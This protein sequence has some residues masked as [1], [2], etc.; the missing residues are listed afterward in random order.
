MQ[1]RGGK[2]TYYDEAVLLH[3]LQITHLNFYNS[4]I[5]AFALKYSIEQFLDIAYNQQ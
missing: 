4:L 1:K 3:N 5:L 2:S